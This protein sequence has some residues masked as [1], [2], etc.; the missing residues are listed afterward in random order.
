MASTVY[1]ARMVTRTK[2]KTGDI[3]KDIG[4]FSTEA[5]AKEAC[6]YHHLSTSINRG[7]SVE[8]AKALIS[9]FYPQDQRLSAFVDGLYLTRYDVTKMRIR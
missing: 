5:K 4:A 1:L 3:L 6:K 7:L 2:A 8:Q 9:S